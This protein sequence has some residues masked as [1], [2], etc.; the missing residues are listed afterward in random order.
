MI[1]VRFQNHNYSLPE[2]WEELSTQQVETLAKLAQTDMPQ[3][4][5]LFR[6]ALYCMDMRMAWRYSVKVS[7]LPC[8]YVRHGIT[9]VYLVSPGQMAVLASSMQWLIEDNAIKP[10]SIKNPYHE[11]H[12]GRKKFFGPADGLSNLLTKEWILAE[13]ER[14]QYQAT[15]NEYHLN[16]FLA[17][18]WRPKASNHPDGDK[19]A[20]FR[21]DALDELSQQM[22]KFKPHQKQVMLWFYNECLEYLSNKFEPVFSNSEEGDGDGSVIDNFMQMVTNLAKDDLSK[23]DKVY[24]APLYQTLY[25]LQSILKKAEDKKQNQ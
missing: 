2:K 25:T 10:N 19:R 4:E 17:I 1:N 5:L 9:R 11:V 18:L 16:R 23:T 13:V 20:P 22:G 3:V 7:G 15:Q 14:S 8:Y 21:Q 24:N 6:F 12:I